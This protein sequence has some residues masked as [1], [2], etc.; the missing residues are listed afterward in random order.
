MAFSVGGM[1]RTLYALG[2]LTVLLLWTFWRA[3]VESTTSLSP[4]GCGMSYMSP[5]YIPQTA[6]DETWTPLARR[7]SLI[8]YRESGWQE[9]TPSGLPVFFIPGNAGSAHQVRSVASSAARTYYEKPGTVANG[10]DHI[11]PLDFFALEH[12]EDLSALHGPTLE[13]EAA[14]A[15]RAL[16]Y[17]ASLYPKDTPIILMGHSMGGVVAA[18]LLAPNATNATI[19]ALVTLSAPHTLPPA[20]LDRRIA[21]FYSTLAPG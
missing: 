7:Y 5:N 6:F 18:S 21:K 14:Y 4:Q 20:R 17:I 13:A 15:G 16:D 1:Y 9:G 10:M 2:L 12:N 3:G 8:L 11:R 19:S